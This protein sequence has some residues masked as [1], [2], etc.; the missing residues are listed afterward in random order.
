MKRPIGSP[1]LYLA[2]SATEKTPVADSSK[3]LHSIV[4]ALERC[5]AI[6]AGSGNSGTAQLVSLAILE[7]QM[8]LNGIAE[9]ELKALCDAMTP[10]EEW[11]EDARSP[12]KSPQG[13]RRRASLKLVHGSAAG[14]K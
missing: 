6:L 4:A 14:P 8:K 9:A 10:Q 11:A 1:Q 2:S 5:R 13:Q 7:L 12:P 3:P